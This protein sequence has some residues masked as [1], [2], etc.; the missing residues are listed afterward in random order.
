M[1]QITSMALPQIG[2][3]A[4]L[5]ALGLA[6]YSFLVGAFA[7]FGGP[8][9]DH[10]GE[11][12]RR[13]GIATFGTVVLASVAAGH[14]RLH[15]RFLR[16][17]HLPSQQPRSS[18]SLQVR[19]SLVR[20]G[21]LAAV[22]VAAAFDLRICPA[23]APQDRSAPFRVRLGRHRSRPGLLSCSAEFRRPSLRACWKGTSLPTAPA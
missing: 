14:C 8:G 15:R 21:R 18:R 20:P 16:R 3:F 4:L 10:L 17:L 6:G 9:S 1:S 2:S 7:L 23:P 19:R 22:L 13:A 12:A 5:L 11:T